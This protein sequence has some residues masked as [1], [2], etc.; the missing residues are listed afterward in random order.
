MSM[1]EN[2]EYIK[3]NG[4]NKFIQ[5]ENE[6]WKCPDCNGLIC[7]HRGYCLKCKGK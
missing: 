3:E 7:V 2:Q 1:L 4:I 6:K 5:K